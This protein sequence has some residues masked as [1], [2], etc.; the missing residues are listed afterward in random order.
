MGFVDK[1][2]SA[3]LLFYRRDF[4]QRRSIPQRAIDAFHDYQRVD[5]TLPKTS[6]AFV[7]IAGIVVWIFSNS[8]PTFLQRAWK[9]APAS[10]GMGSMPASCSP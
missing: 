5:T 8:S 7:E 6:Q 9:S 10:P 3:M 4:R 2:T 1:Q